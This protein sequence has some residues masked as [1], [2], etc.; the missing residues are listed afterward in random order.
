LAKLRR[1]KIVPI[2]GPPCIGLFCCVILCCGYDTYFFSDNTDEP[3]LVLSLCVF[4]DS[5][6][7]CKMFRL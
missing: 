7:L 2:F 6:T 5:G 4:A 1:T 3:H